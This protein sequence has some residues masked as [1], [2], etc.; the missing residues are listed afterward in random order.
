MG[1]KLQKKSQINVVYLLKKH[2]KKAAILKESRLL[3]F[4]NNQP[5]Q[6]VDVLC[7]T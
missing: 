2:K 6:F 5:L 4:F 3:L 1:A 7:Q